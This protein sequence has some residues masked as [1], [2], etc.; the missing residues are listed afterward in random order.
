MITDPGVENYLYALLPPSG[1]VLEEMEREAAAR[2][3][4]IVGPAVARLFRLLAEL[5]GA[6]RVFELGSAIGY[7]TIWWAQAVGAEGEVFYTD[8]SADNAREAAGYCRRAGVEERVRILQGEAL[9]LFDATP[10]EFDIVFLDLNKDQY[11]E[12]LR[13]AVPRIRPG[14][15][16]VADN[17]LWRGLVALPPQTPETA[18]M[19]EFNRR[20]YADPRLEPV[21][22]PLRD[23]VAVARVTRP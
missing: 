18:A 12:A 7:S 4:P 14:G 17:V 16:L 8:S 22:L 13:R 23:G 9:A 2:K 10:G 6:K 21:I 19:A 20:L 1:P 15:L 3:V 5:C 11:A